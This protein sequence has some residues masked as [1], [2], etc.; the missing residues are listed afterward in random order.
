MSFLEDLFKGDNTGSLIGAG[1]GLLAGGSSK[2]NE[3]TQ[4]N[5]QLDPRIA[6]YIYGENGSSGLLGDAQSIY[7]QQ[8]Q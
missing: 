8:M 6:K 2:G 3:T 4:T 1:L 7:Q 5:N